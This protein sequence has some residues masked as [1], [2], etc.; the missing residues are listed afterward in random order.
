M[1]VNK[2]MRDYE[3]FEL[4]IDNINRIAEKQEALTAEEQYSAQVLC[5]E[6][7]TNNSAIIAGLESG[8]YFPASDFKKTLRWRRNLETL[9]KYCA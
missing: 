1:T 3:A 9:K 7:G 8:E 6:L 4:I 5:A 2:T